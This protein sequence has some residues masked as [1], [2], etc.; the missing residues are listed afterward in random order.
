MGTTAALKLPN[1][2]GLAV[3]RKID[4]GNEI[5]CFYEKMAS[6]LRRLDLF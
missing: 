5:T 2:L 1:M 3:V 4:P 6:F